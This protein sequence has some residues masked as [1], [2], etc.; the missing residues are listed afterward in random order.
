M[1]DANA[2]T[3]PNDAYSPPLV[4]EQVREMDP[5]QLAWLSGYLYCLSRQDE[6]AAE[7]PAETDVPALPIH[8]VYASQTGNGK[9]VA[10]QL[11][12]N[13]ERAGLRVGLF[14]AAEFPTA[15]LKKP[16]RLLLVVSTHG[17]GEPP[18]EAKEFY[19]D[20]MNNGPKDLSHVKFSV[21]ALGDSSYEHF[22]RTGR[23]LDAQLESLGA[24]RWFDLI[25]CDVDFKPQS[26]RWEKDIL[27]ELEGQKETP[28]VGGTAGNVIPFRRLKTVHDRENPF[29]AALGKK[30]MLCDQ[31]AEKEVFHLEFSIEG[32]G[33]GYLPGDS[34]GVFPENS[35]R[36]A[37]RFLNFMGGNAQAPFGEGNGKTTL[38]KAA[39]NLFELKR[40]TRH[41]A[42]SLAELE[43]SSFPEGI[44]ANGNGWDELLK[45]CDVV[46][47][48]EAHASGVNRERIPPLLSEIRPRLYSIAS[49]PLVHEDEVHLT[50]RRE[51]FPLGERE[52][53][54]LGSGFL[55]NLATEGTARVYVQPNAKFRLPENPDA[56]IVMIGAGTGIAPYRSFLF[57]REAL[58]HQGKSW[59]FFGEQKFFATFLYQAE[60]RSFLKKGVLTRF[61]GAFSRDAERKTYVSDKLAERSA[62]VYE[63]I[64]QG[65]VIYVCGDAQ[66]MAK[67][68]EATLLEIIRNRGKTGAGEAEE[69][70][71]ELSAQGRYLKD[72]Y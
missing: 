29:P 16:Q 39:R 12:K 58:G 1:L 27:K 54:G 40:P 36:D 19:D 22:C 20:L 8:V 50:V 69:R 15:K 28:S 62:E 23:E 45:G 47:L 65:A 56:P 9:S 5:H 43:G 52:E 31:G 42:R 30:V 49:S 64:R 53:T 63:W 51:V 59:L 34:L 10:E 7:K 21:F 35:A 14:N 4:P 72:V 11:A 68:V 48:L 37:E 55:A 71:D 24:E 2:T 18:D 60:W 66:R 44:L 6:R 32:S 46:D 41:L 26:R 57:Q 33:I 3:F 70:L 25:E 17:N 13:L 61:N 67:D 38:E